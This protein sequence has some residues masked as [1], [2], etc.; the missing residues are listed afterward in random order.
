MTP[1]ETADVLKKQFGDA[2][3]DRVEFRGEVT[4]T[5]PRARIL[6]VCRFLKE[7]CSFEMLTDLSGVDNYGEDPR[8]AVDYLL[9]SYKHGCYFRVK[10]AVPEDDIAVDSVV[11]VWKTA[12]WHEREAFDM[13]GIRFTGHPNLKRILMWEGYPYH[14]LR[15]D[16]PLAGLPAELPRTAVNAGSVD[17][18][19]MLGGPFVAGTGKGGAIGREPRQYDTVAEQLDKQANPARKEAV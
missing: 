12:N 10:V 1:Q 6:E 15:K 11:G 13:Y 4:V 18:A 3:T 7:E 19:P 5:V 17:Q 16:F 8:F 9:H 14:P 2:V